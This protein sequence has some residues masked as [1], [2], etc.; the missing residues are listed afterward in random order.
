[1]EAHVTIEMVLLVQD[2]SFFRLADSDSD[3]LDLLCVVDC[4]AGGQKARLSLF[5]ATR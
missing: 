1:M 2:G 5:G 3:M 4:V